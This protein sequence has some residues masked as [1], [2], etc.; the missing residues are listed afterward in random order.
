VTG[1]LKLAKM[2][3]SLQA[4]ESTEVTCDET[5]TGSVCSP[6]EAKQGT[7]VLGE[8]V[9]RR[10]PGNHDSIDD[11]DGQAAVRSGQWEGAR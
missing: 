7:P 4:N 9:I 5:T 3:R 2:V 8:T 1:L 6:D 11:D 10:A